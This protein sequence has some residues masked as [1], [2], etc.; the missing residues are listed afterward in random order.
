V[1]WGLKSLNEGEDW[2]EA[3]AV[4]GRQ[5][6]MAVGTDGN[7]KNAGWLGLFAS[8]HATSGDAARQVWSPRYGNPPADA[9]LVGTCASRP[10]P[11]T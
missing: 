10:A 1:T 11:A 6:A 9:L 2:K 5:P 7:G 8:W 3:A 4:Q